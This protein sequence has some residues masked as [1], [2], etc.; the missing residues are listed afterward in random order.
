MNAMLGVLFALAIFVTF[1]DAECTFFPLEIS[2]GGE[3][4]GCR[5]SKGELHAFNTQWE[6]NCMRCSC[7]SRYGLVCCS[8]VV[9]PKDYD[10]VACKEIFN[11]Q[12]CT[13]SVVEKAN[14]AVACNVPRY[15][16]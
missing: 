8:M 7:N 1:C 3:P 11:Q 6:S 10:N 4:E 16:G 12:S 13:I 2:P 5:D 14:P 15:S 9:K